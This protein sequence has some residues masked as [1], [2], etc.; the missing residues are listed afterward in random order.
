LR[1]R[2]FTIP[3]TA[4][5][6]ITMNEIGRNDLCPCGSGKKYKKCHM[7]GTEIAG[8]SGGSGKKSDRVR[9]ANALRVAL[10]RH[11]AGR[12]ADA[13]NIYWQILQEFPGEFDA[14]H[15]LGMAAHESGDEEAAY[16]LIS[17]A[18]ALAPDHAEMHNNLGLVLLALGRLDEASASCQQAIALN[19]DFASAHN[20]LGAVYQ[21]QG[22]LDEAVASYFL[23]IAKAPE[24]ALAFNNLGGALQRQGKLDEAIPYY[25]QAIALQ[26]NYTDAIYG[27]GRVYNAQG[28][29]DEALACFRRVAEIDPEHGTAQHMIAALT[30]EHAEQAPAAYVK[31]VFDTYADTFDVH[32]G[33]VLNYQTPEQLVALVTASAPAADEKWDVLDLG[34]G[35]G[36]A[37]VAIAPFARK[38]VGVDLSGK[39]LQKA[40]QKNIYARLVEAEL[41]DM[42]RGEIAASYD[43]V[44][45]AD[46]FVY[47]GKLDAVFLDVKRVLRPGGRFAF[48]IEALEPQMAADGALQEGFRLNPSGRF[49]HA[50]DYASRLAVAAGFEVLAMQPAQLRLE[51]GAPVNGCLVL[52]ENKT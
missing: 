13:G 21:N 43:V 45:T 47:L 38:L 44:I 20:N 12:L 39:M 32:L 18:I 24:Y 14:L 8:L 51:N 19:P 40:A 36:L 49:A 22:R 34:C 16:D 41:V 2:R 11:Q 33:Q 15:L 5:A 37:G 23:A 4:Q 42:L 35:T 17:K 28:R 26:P 10:A 46:V 29:Q 25:E 3:V 30:G 9:V 31:N 1:F 7:P 52:C 48:S 50:P 27:V 6:N